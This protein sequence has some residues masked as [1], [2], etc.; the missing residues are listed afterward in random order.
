L[1]PEYA[2]FPN[3]RVEVVTW[4]VSSTTCDVFLTGALVY[5]LVRPPFEI[6]AYSHNQPNFKVD[7]KNER[8]LD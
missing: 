7:T 5:S 8:D 1:H 2:S 3:F 4:L 6:P